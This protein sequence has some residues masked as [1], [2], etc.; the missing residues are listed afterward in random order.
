MDKT[1]LA[2]FSDPMDA[3]AAIDDLQAHDFDAKDISVMAH[4]QNMPASAEGTNT[5]SPGRGTA[6]GAIVG[7]LAGLLATAVTGPVGLV[8]AG[9]FFAMITGGIAGGV[10][11]WFVDLGTSRETAESY[12]TVVTNGGVVIAV[13]TESDAEE[14]EARKIFDDHRADHVTTVTQREHAHAA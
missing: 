1:L 13:P 3:S 9:P 5:S 4:E 2:A 8:F 6:S 10:I 14:K 11:G 12:Q 7:G